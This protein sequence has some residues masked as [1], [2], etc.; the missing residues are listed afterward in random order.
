MTYARIKRLLSILVF[1]VAIIQMDG[2]LLGC[3]QVQ[4]DFPLPDQEGKINLAEQ[5]D[6]D[7]K[8]FVRWLSQVRGMQIFNDGQ[9]DNA[10]NKVKFYGQDNDVD[11]DE[12]F[13]LVQAV[14]RSN[15]L[16]IVQSDVEGWYRI[17]KLAD[18][19]AFAPEKDLDSL[20]AI[21]RAEYTTAVFTLEN[22]T[23]ESVST[24]LKDLLYA[25]GNTGSSMT[26]VP[27]RKILIVT[28]TA[29]KLL[30]IQEM[31][32]RLDQPS[33]VVRP[34]FHKVIHLSSDQLADQLNRI[35]TQTT[36]VPDNG[37]QS[38]QPSG[39]KGLGGSGLNV[40]SNPRTNELILIGTTEQIDEAR[41]LIERL[42][43][44][45]GLELKRYRFE[46]VQASRIDEL[47]KQ[48]L[49]AQDEKAIQRIYQSS[50][51][52]DSN[53]LIITASEEIH[54][55]VEQFQKQLDVPSQ[56]ENEQDPMQFYTLKNVKAIDILDTIQSIER[57]FLENQR[58]LA[59]RTSRRLT[60]ISTRD[61][62]GVNGPNQLNPGQE[63]PI[64]PTTFQTPPNA[65]FNQ[66]PNAPMQGGFP[67]G[68]ANGNSF[69]SPLSATS[70]GFGRGNGNVIPGEAKVT[71]HEDSNT[72]IVVAEPAVQQLY[73]SL[74]KRLDVRRPQVLIEVNIVTLTDN[75][76]FNLGIEIAGG[77][78]TGDSRA[79]SFTSFGLSETD[80]TSGSLTLRPGLGFNG[81]LVDPNIA[82]VVLRALARHRRAKVIAAPRILVNDNATGLLSSVAEVPFTSINAANTVSTTSFA[83]FA[84]AGTTIAVTPQI[85][86][87][88]YLNLEFDVLV[89]DF[90]G[91][92]SDGVPPPRNTD[93]VTSEVSI[94]DGHT[95][96]V[97][98]LTRR[99]LSEDI[100]GLPLIE[101]LP[102][103]KELTNRQIKATEGQR[104]FVFIRPVILRDDK[105]KDLRFL[106][107]LERNRAQL[108]DDFPAS[109][110]VL[111]R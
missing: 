69:A 10:T 13:E 14:L 15:D 79:F 48:S 4:D 23:A 26:V 60:G 19:R 84:Q 50:V 102:I 104:L 108:P 59:G 38:N 106:S 80:G 101:Q 95:V 49:G 17:V 29:K 73:A 63:G 7:L 37:I 16:A 56:R 94:P 68:T 98:G 2:S 111:I 41:E 8:G 22:S 103:L 1:A 30:R 82:D 33:D 28:E 11:L 64:T 81:T 107:E 3:V 86:E 74:I 78:R 70:A 93:Q 42:D 5:A 62:F 92:G 32:D 43:V 71:I 55:R 75:D 90:T 46:Y 24:Y 72:L 27:G 109:S 21:P 85:S 45:L 40:S 57:R 31:I 12:M 9:L 54:Q 100:Q 105:F 65:N 99:R 20:P 25:K 77:D 58:S 88:N 83:G 61:G 67:N 87:D 89:N 39:V 47:V 18:T 44:S 36:R 52:T 34:Y 96:I 97:G 6:L 66:N 91:S 110:P 51:R 35:L 76:D 53:Q